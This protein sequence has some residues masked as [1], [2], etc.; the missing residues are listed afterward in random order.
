VTS[1]N[2][3]VENIRLIVLAT[4]IITCVVAVS[5]ALI[6]AAGIF[7]V[8]VLAV[9]FGVFLSRVS[10]WVASVLPVGYGWSLTIV[11]T[12]LIVV[13]LGGLVLFGVQIDSQIDKAYRH[14]YVVEQQIQQLADKHPAINT[15]LQ[16][17]PLL[18]QLVEEPEG[19]SKKNKA[20]DKTGDNPAGKKSGDKK[21]DDETAADKKTGDE[22]SG[23][24]TGEKQNAGKAQSLP[25]EVKQVAS[26]VGATLKSVFATSL[27]L[28]VNSLVIFFVGLFLAV[29]PEKYRDGVVVL[30]PPSRRER[31]RELMNGMGD[32][33]WYWLLGRF[34]SMLVTGAGAAIIL[35]VLGVPMALT[36]GVLT[37]LL[38]FIPNIGGF[39]ALV[40]SA[41]C[42]IP[43]GGSTV[44]MVIAGYLLMQLIESY[45]VTP[46]IQQ[47]QV[48][49]PPALL[50]FFQ[51]LLGVLFGILGAAVASPLLAAGK[52][53]IQEAYIKDVLENGG[54]TNSNGDDG[55][56]NGKEEQNQND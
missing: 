30:F 2:T 18:R 43:L 8:L 20:G 29:A 13:S 22:K 49:L 50:I 33:M 4:A 12:L 55:N 7:L 11:T 5:A 26:R 48:S 9:L 32:T 35:L 36:L 42:A 1:G 15:A 23:N 10:R 38:T 19:S 41:L 16:Q 21:S 54:K 24:K 47:Q 28:V 45:V 56:A 52:F 17:T 44:L 3:L 40:L 51:A 34:G 25:A 6:Y 53:L 39:L 14:F 27:G 31:T 46:L 37:A